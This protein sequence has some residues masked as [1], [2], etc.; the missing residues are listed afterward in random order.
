MSV[1]RHEALAGQRELDDQ[2]GT[3]LATRAVGAIPLHDL[4]FRVRQ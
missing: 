2:H 1:Q 3:R 4:D